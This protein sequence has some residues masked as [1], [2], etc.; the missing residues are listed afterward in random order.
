LNQR[1]SIASQTLGRLAGSMPLHIAMLLGVTFLTWGTPVPTGNEQHYLAVL[2]RMWDPAFLA[3]DWTFS[4]SLPDRWTFDA[5]FGALALFLPV[6][7]IGWGGRIACWI[8]SSWAIL[9]I[10]RRLG[11]P[12]PLAAMGTAVWLLLGQS[13][14][15]GEWMLGWFEAKAVAWVFLLFAIDG[16]MAGR[17]IRSC[18]FAGLAATFHPAVGVVGGASLAVAIVAMH[19]PVRDLWRPAL[20]GVAC[21]LPGLIQ[22]G[23]MT[24]G[25]EPST[26]DDWHFLAGTF[27]RIH[28]DAR[29][30]DIGLLAAL[31]L[32]VAFT[33]AWARWMRERPAFRLV[34]WMHLVPAVLF[35]FGLASQ[36]A[37][38]WNFMTL[39]PYR[40]LPV[41]SLL[42]FCLFVA[43]MGFQAMAAPVGR[44][45]PLA[46]MAAFLCMPALPPLVKADASRLI[47]TWTS[48]PDP[49]EQAFEWIAANIPQG[50]TGLIPP[51]RGDA[52][53]LAR[54]G[55]IAHCA[56]PRYD[57]LAAWTG[58][59]RD[60][61]GDVTAE[62]SRDL[63]L[64]WNRAKAAWKAMT[65]DQ[66]LRL[67]SRYSA[68]FLVS[69]AELP[70]AQ[71]CRFGPVKVY[72][73]P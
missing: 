50:E 13:L 62:D 5:I 23:L 30:F 12:L 24:L 47:D 44:L 65:S 20:A 53:L 37:G 57:R 64:P 17:L 46:A 61:L 73:L 36:A 15:G 72:R 2:Q 19:R 55:Q 39:T 66:A 48:A 7:A 49:Y 59:I 28:F 41:I 27:M 10:G 14:V 35:L 21:G 8:L 18:A 16:A 69:E 3:N 34:A 38:A 52:V 45:A 58:R 29:T 25:A 54:R 32:S 11:I 67:A 60:Q 31:V 70:F 26:A 6:Q 9:R 4:T 1:S 33:L 22:A 51:W 68:T 40:L 42:S 43:S 63:A 56:M 71:S